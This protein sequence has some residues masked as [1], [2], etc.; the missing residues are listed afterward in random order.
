MGASVYRNF[1][2]RGVRQE[3]AKDGTNS[4]CCPPE[5]RGRMG[6][7]VANDSSMNA[8]G[9]TVTPIGQIPDVKYWDFENASFGG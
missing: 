4:I 7:T 5:K 9:G 8:K 2:S 6:G 1:V 3:V